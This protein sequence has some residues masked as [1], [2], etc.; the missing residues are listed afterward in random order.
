MIF[1]AARRSVNG[2][3][4]QP[5]EIRNRGLSWVLL[6]CSGIG[7]SGQSSGVIIHRCGVKERIA[8]SG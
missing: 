4:S 7:G 3:R 5:A 1:D 6:Y 2:K 8:P